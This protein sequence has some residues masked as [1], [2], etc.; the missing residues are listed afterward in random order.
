MRIFNLVDDGDDDDG[1]RNISSPFVCC[2]GV[3]LN[4]TVNWLTLHDDISSIGGSLKL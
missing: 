3:H 1:W 2:D 4:G